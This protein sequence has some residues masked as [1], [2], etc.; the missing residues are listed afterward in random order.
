MSASAKTPAFPLECANA[1]CA[2]PLQGPVRFCP[3]CGSGS[4]VLAAPAASKVPVAA[5]VARAAPVVTAVAAQSATAPIAKPRAPAP[6][7][8]IVAAKPAPKPAPAIPVV[9]A[10]PRRLGRK[11]ALVG[12]VLAAIGGYGA[13]QMNARNALQQFEADLAAGQGCLRSNRFD[14][15]LENAERALRT[16]SKDPRALSLLQ[17]AQAGLERQQRD[18]ETKAQ[19]V[20]A[21]ANRAA[22]RKAANEQARQEREARAVAERERKAQD[23]VAAK[24]AQALQEL[25]SDQAEVNRKQ[26]QYLEQQRQAQRQVQQ[27]PLTRP[28][29]RPTAAPLNPG[30]VGQQLSQARRA[31]ARRDGNAARALANTV[32]RQDPGNRQA[33]NILRQAEQLRGR[34]QPSFDTPKALGGVIIE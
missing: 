12:A 9:A 18:Q 15:A 33:Q 25:L 1:A 30:L 5:S 23:Q 10:R 26:Q 2:R 3:Y 16:D 7:V 17:R 31:L 22:A 21:A 6:E 29:P 27:A 32:L 24:Q 13:Y 19:A 14:C 4:Q 20:A 34:Q 28:A 8:A 11:L